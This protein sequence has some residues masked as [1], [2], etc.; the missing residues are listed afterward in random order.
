MSDIEKEEKQKQAVTSEVK[1]G[2]QRLI[3]L[4]EKAYQV[5]IHI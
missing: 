5:F 4:E 2:S 1:I 3:P